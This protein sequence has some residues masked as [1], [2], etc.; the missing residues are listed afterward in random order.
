VEK[1]AEEL[2]D[3]M[4]EAA[5]R[6]EWR[7]VGLMLDR[8]FGRPKETVAAEQEEPEAIKALSAPTLEQRMLLLHVGKYGGEPPPCAVGDE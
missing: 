3:L 4:I 8:V 7:V 6:G 1:H 5:R 2:T